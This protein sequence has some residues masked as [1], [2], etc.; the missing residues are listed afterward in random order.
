MTILQVDLETFCEVP[1]NNG[2]YIYAENCEVMLFAWAVDEEPPQVWDLT[3]GGAMP[4]RLEAMLR[5]P[6][7]LIQASNSMFDR[8]V[9]RLAT[10]SHPA[11]R[12]AGAQIERWRDTMVQAL[13]HSMPGALGKLGPILGLPE[14]QQKD[15]EGKKYIQLFCK[16][17]PKNQELRRATRE[18]HPAE[19]A[20][21]AAYAGQDITPMRE[22]GKRAPTWNYK[23][24]ELA[25]WHLDQKIND[26]G[27]AIDLELA[28]A[29]IAA[30][31]KEQASLAA[32]AVV[33]TDGAVE[34]TTK[35]DKLLRYILS[36]YGVDLPDM[37]ASTLER[38][39]G[40]PDLPWALR[41]LLAVRLMASTASTSKYKALLKSTSSDSRLR[42]LLQF[43]GAMRT[44]RWAGRTFQPQNLPRPSLSQAWID[45]AIAAM[46]SGSEDLIFENVMQAASSAIRGVIIAP[47]GKK[48]VVADLSNIEGRMLAWLAGE[49]W[50]LKAFA[51]FDAGHG[52]DLYALAYA[53]SF[54]ITPEAVMKNKKEG[55]GSM[56]QIGK[57]QELALGYEGGV[58]AFLTFALAYGIELDEMAEQ[59]DIPDWAWDRAT[60]MLEWHREQKRDPLA[61]SGLEEKTWLVCE[62]LKTMWR[63]AHPRTRS[64]WTDLGDIVRAA[65]R[66]PGRRFECR[67]F[68]IQRD[69]AWLRI[70]LPSGRCLCYPQPEVADGPRGQISYMGVN[71]YSRKWARIHTYGGKLIEN[72]TQAA[73]RDI[74]AA[75]MPA[76]E[77]AGYQITLT[78]HDE[79]ITEAPDSPEFN[80]EHL[81]ALLSQNPPW[82]E[83]LPLAAAG[84]QSYR[85]KK[86]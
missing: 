32:R 15:K 25:L 66:A 24:A 44:G 86:D 10:N 22:V 53:K 38:R 9:F 58:G 48:L 29:A 82:A 68:V 81:S 18:T 61:S 83:G 11:M 30:V 77:A 57:V 28:N 70:R 21:F 7:V 59:A 1:I 84:F 36:T 47:P 54:G 35:R 14:D 51:D 43:C 50:K 5:N 27:V 67:R 49:D 8:T 52:H 37:Q 12:A 76:V 80:E 3:A 46:K 79:L 73:A 34:S 71:Q 41:E 64:L 63:E 75:A 20:G 17:R 19:W 26:R 6:A 56:R 74:L 72:A 2:T 60:D 42:G 4:Q 33:L 40:D 39:V 16:P 78:V 62:A 69:G 23:G 85:Y 13:A 65:I 45:I 31:T 55:D